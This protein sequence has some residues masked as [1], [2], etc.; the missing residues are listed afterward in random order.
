M[1]TR[2]FEDWTLA[3]VAAH[4]AKSR[5]RR[6]F[7]L[8]SAIRPSDARTSLLGH[9]D[10]IT[11][12]VKTTPL[13]LRGHKYRA[14]PCIV[15]PDL[16]L[17][18][19]EDIYRAEHAKYGGGIPFDLPASLKSRAERCGIVGIWFGSL[20]EGR[21]YIELKQLEKAGAIARLELQRRWPLVSIIARTNLAGE[22]T[23]VT[24][25]RVEHYVSDFSY[26]ELTQAAT[27]FVV[28]D[29]KGLLTRDY[30]RKSKH[31]AAQYGITILET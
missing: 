12:D 19:K 21:R 3:D 23:G 8:D 27:V 1:A 15:T 25:E 17:F 5:P 6:T 28:E 31:F 7:G 9:P 14:E 10:A 30:V 13:P 20:K 16:T 22:R 26:D 24:V 29:C 2:G 4:A 18:T 11:G